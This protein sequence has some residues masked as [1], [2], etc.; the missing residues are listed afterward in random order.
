MLH[1]SILISFVYAAAL[2]LFSCGGE[3]TAPPIEN[4]ENYANAHILLPDNWD[5]TFI[6]ANGFVWIWTNDVALQKKYGIYPD[7]D[8]FYDDYEIW[9]ENDQYYKYPL[10]PN[11]EIYAGMFADPYNWSDTEIMT[12]NQFGDYL[13]K[14]GYT[15]GKKDY[16]MISNVTFSKGK[17]TK[18]EEKFTP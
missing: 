18:I 5:G 15:E 6:L 11:V 8:N 14:R 13:R 9:D 7:G 12:I 1:K 3:G 17:I 2:V 4:T 10:S 16:G